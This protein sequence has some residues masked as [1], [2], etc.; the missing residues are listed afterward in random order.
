MRVENYL[1]ISFAHTCF[2]AGAG[3]RTEWLI[4]LNSV[5]P[6]GLCVCVCV[7][8]C[9]GGGQGGVGGHFDAGGVQ[10]GSV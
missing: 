6:E 2:E 10:S 7:C 3:I 4:F 9:V 1:G 5:S 8:V